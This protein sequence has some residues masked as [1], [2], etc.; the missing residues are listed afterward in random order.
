MT[1]E[2]VVS[3]MVPQNFLAPDTGTFGLEE[4][5]LGGLCLTENV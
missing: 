3:L 5:C 4:L 2:A 1:A